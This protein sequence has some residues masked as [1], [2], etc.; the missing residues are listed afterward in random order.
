MR[1]AV[2]GLKDGHIQGMLGSALQS[3]A[4]ELVGVVE[5]DEEICRKALR[6]REVPRYASLDELIAEERPELI[7][8][9]LNH[10]RKL[11]LVEKAAA[12]GIHLLLDKPL[13]SNAEH[14]RRMK[15]AV[16]TSGIKLSMWFT[17]RSYPPFVALRERIMAGELGELISFVSTHP[18]RLSVA[19]PP[20][21]LDPQVYTGTFADL[22]CH[23]VDMIRWLSGAEYAGVHALAATKKRHIDKPALTDHVQASFALSDG[24]RAVLTADWLTPPA[25]PYWGDTRFI[26][27]GSKGTAHLRAYAENHVLV[28]SDERGSTELSVEKVNAKPFVAEMIDSLENGRELFVSTDDVFAVAKACLAAEESARRGGEFIRI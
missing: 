28:L 24:A 15:Q 16:D 8:E 3:A 23:G 10:A 4:A 20:W 22:A 18:H 9:G 5:P 27:M 7:L 14:W 1:V 6:G 21:Y 13:C 19:H 17:A 26:I 11:E 25:S 2:M 12:A